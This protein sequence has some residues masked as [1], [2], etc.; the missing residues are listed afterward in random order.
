MVML[1][2]VLGAQS[3]L[4][5]QRAL[6]PQAGVHPSTLQFPHLSPW[7]GETFLESFQVKS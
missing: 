2:S 4:A 3:L 1:D 7:S 6:H 5:C